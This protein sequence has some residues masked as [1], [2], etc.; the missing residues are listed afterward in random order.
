MLGGDDLVYYTTK[1]GEIKAGGYSV[2]STMLQKK[3]PVNVNVNV[4]GKKKNNSINEINVSDKFNT[5]VVPAGLLYLDEN[6]N[7][8]TNDHEPIEVCEMND[9]VPDDLYSKLMNLAEIKEKQKKTTRA[10]KHKIKKRKNITK[11]AKY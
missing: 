5:M 7:T 11:R 3:K 4:G 8:N 1:N 9:I 2:N 6:L 10:R